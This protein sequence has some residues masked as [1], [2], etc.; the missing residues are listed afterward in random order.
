M[1]VAAVM[2][3]QAS[4]EGRRFRWLATSAAV[5]TFLLIVIG[6]VVR[7][8]GSG[9]GCPDWPLCYGRIIPPLR[10]DA[11]IEYSH[12]LVASLA[13]PLIL[14]TAAAIWLRYRSA[15]GLLWA[16]SLSVVLLIIQIALGGVTVLMELPP[17][18]VALHLGN[19]LLILALQIVLAVTTFR[20][21][22]LGRLAWRSLGRDPLTRIAS[23][24]VFFT[25]ILLVSGSIVTASGS[26]WACTTWPLCAGTVFPDN[27][28][29]RMHML[30]RF[31]AAAGGFLLLALALR[32]WSQ[33]HARPA[34]FVASAVSFTLLLTQVGLGALGV[35]RGFS[36]LVAGLHVATATSVWAG[37]VITLTFSGLELTQGVQDA[38]QP[39]AS[40]NVSLGDF[41]SLTKPLIVGLLLLTTFA[42]MVVGAGG[43][44]GTSL[45]IWTLLGGALAAGGSGAL[46]QLIDRDLDGR[47][48]RTSDRP[49]PSGRLDTPEVIAFG[50]ILC[51]LS[52]YT[53]AV[54]VNLLSALLSLFGILYY[55]FFYSLLLKPTTPQNIVI[56][57]GA[58]AIPPLVGWAAATGSLDMGAF[59]LF[60]LVFFW[61][62]PHFWALALVRYKDY[63]RAGLPMLPVVEGERQTRRLILLYTIQ[64]VMLSLLMPLINVG[65]ALFLFLAAAVGAGLIYFASALW[66]GG[67]NRRAWGMYRYSSLYL[68]L[69]FTALIL[70][71]LVLN[72]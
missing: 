54:F 4:S 60:A 1:P 65:G 72:P 3:P 36:P 45:V 63:A 48:Q 26:T 7:V 2:T 23:F 9:L 17:T 38:S 6:G 43:W 37:A 24:A 21:G 20:L 34:T 18:I 42:A 46:N 14:G 8:T 27:A 30:H 12:R 52:F 58:G 19:A 55:V 15:P 25:F 62:P 5:A 22:I 66:K 53:L 11:L 16:S 49:L 47:M 29:G 59:L 51:I 41:L 70:D 64:V 44:P 50:I 67:G 56:G 68:A 32:A 71:T 39:E 69:I 33:R 28:L 57:G 40:A 35:L 31:T 61:T 10:F 13:S